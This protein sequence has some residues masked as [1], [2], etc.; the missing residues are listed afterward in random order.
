MDRRIY[1][2]LD[3]RIEEPTLLKTFDSWFY[4]LKS[5]WR[6]L[7][8]EVILD[9]ETTFLGI[10]NCRIHLVYAKMKIRVN[11]LV[12]DFKDRYCYCICYNRFM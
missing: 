7:H 8:I 12:I 5:V 11:G 1:G 10:L 9:F 2:W 6:R 3:G 4:C